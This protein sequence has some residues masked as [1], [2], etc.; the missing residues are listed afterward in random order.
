MPLDDPANTAPDTPL[1]LEV[2]VRLAFPAGGMSVSGLRR[3]ARRGNLVLEKIAGKH[4]TTL[5]AIE[6]MRAK[7]RD[8]VRELGSGSNLSKSTARAKSSATR[9]GSSATDRVKSARAA[10]EM[11]A[12]ALTRR[13]ANTSPVQYQVPRERGRHP[14]EI[15]VLDVL[16]MYLTEVAKREGA[17]DGNQTARADARGVL[18]SPTRSP[19]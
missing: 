16:N 11:T 17:T 12:K 18:G 9:R 14:T 2:A 5:R 19:M 6:E 3:E 4:F 10:L 7:C 15:L 13:S 1:R 8:Q